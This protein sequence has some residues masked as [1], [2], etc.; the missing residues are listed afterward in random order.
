M[1]RAPTFFHDIDG[2]I[3]LVGDWPSEIEI[4]DELL[5]AADPKFLHGGDGVGG[6]RLIDINPCNGSAAYWCERDGEVWRGELCARSL[7]TR[8]EAA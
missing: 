8:R 4:S 7:W 3:W 1:M 5:R 6:Q 2:R